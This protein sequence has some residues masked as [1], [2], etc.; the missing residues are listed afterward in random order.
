MES[1]LDSVVEGCSI[2]TMRR[3]PDASVD[4]VFA[5]PPYNLQLGGELTRPDNSRVDGVDDAW[6][7][8]SSFA[9]YDRFTRDW[10]FEAR[11]VLKPDGAL[12]VIGSYHNIFRVGTILQDLGYWILND[13]VWNKTNPMPNFRGTR[14]TNAHETLIW[15]AR[16]RESKYTFNYAAMKASNDDLQ[17]RSDWSLPIC[18]GGERL[19][20]AG[21]GKAHPTQKP[22]SLLYRVLISTTEVGDV[23]LDPFFGS[24][25]TGAVAKMLGRRYVGLERD[26]DYAA[27][28]RKRIALVE[29]TPL[30]D[31]ETAKSRRSAPR[32]PFGAVVEQGLLRPGASLFAPNRKAEAHIRADGSIA[33]RDEDGVTVQGSIHKIGALVEKA[34]ACNGWTYWQYETATGLKPIDF[35][36]DKMRKQLKA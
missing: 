2:E 16:A 33:V 26:K 5:D 15:A 17:M 3:M 21:G 32:V 13:I 18:T 12:W 24:G 4:L 19:K 9:E 35:L 10:L 30:Q 27:A 1:F 11:R 7:K 22:E 36:R 23:V 14:F 6:D 25:T 28:A 34:E 8:F 29:P 20:V 31:L